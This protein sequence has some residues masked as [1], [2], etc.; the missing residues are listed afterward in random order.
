MFS[1]RNAKVSLNSFS[2]KASWNALGFP[3]SEQGISNTLGNPVGSG[4][5]TE[6]AKDPH[7]SIKFIPSISL[8]AAAI[9]LFWIVHLTLQTP[10]SIRQLPQ[11]WPKTIS[12]VM[13]VLLRVIKLLSIIHISWWHIIPSLLPAVIGTVPILLHKLVH[14]LFIL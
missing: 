9:V 3:A 10:S 4:F 8:F 5:V 11:Y 14:S 6:Q 13:L 12:S 1:P 2:S 7:D